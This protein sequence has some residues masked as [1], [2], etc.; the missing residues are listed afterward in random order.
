MPGAL[1]Y[2]QTHENES[3]ARMRRHSLVEYDFPVYHKYFFFRFSDFGTL[4]DIGCGDGKFVSEA[5]RRGVAAWG[6]D[7][8][9]KSIA[10]AKIRGGENFFSTSVE[11]LPQSAPCKYDGVSIFEVLEHQASPGEFVSSLK[12]LLSPTGLLVGSVPNRCSWAPT[13]DSRWD[14]PPHHFTRWTKDSLRVFF[15]RI[16]FEV[17]FVSVVGHGGFTTAV[18]SRIAAALKQWAFPDMSRE[19]YVSKPLEQF[20]ARHGE[21]LKL[22]FWVQAKRVAKSILFIAAIPEIIA[23]WFLGGGKNI[24]F[25]CRLKAVPGNN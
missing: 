21:G 6:V 14:S 5:R 3:K 9:E 15:S 18:Y 1:Y 12:P 23:S 10:V 7:F 16:G 11:S 25:V 8:D 19:D 22:V 13:E 2:A 24:F 20:D 17:V 4:L